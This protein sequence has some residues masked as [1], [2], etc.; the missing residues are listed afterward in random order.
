MSSKHIFQYRILRYIH[1]SF[2]GE[3]L[4]IGLVLFS[5]DPPY[6]KARLLHKYSRITG[7][8]PNAEGEHYRRYITALQNK[9]DRFSIGSKSDFIQQNYLPTDISDELIST[10]LPPDDSAIQFGPLLG[11]MASNLDLVFDD[12]YTRLIEVYLKPE[13]RSNK[14]DQEIWSLLSKQLRPYNVM[15]HLHHTIINWENEEIELGHAWKNGRW[16]ALEPISFD[17][18][19]S[20]S[21]RNKS[22]Q[23]LGTTVILDKSPILDKLYYLLGKPQ[24]EDK[25]LGVAYQKAKDLLG[26]GEHASKV[27]LIE[28][29]EMEDFARDISQKI[30]SDIEHSE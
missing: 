2:T 30:Q 11:G 25:S 23:W 26:L 18:Q 3:F 10:I 5:Q 17:L 12:L 19:H 21:I 14:D 4:N 24:K 15:H 13:E 28:E 1:D 9:F 7:A 29:D 22:H 27:E 20:G 8:F 16:K 6:F